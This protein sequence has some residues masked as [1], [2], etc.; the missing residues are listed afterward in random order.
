MTMSR[1]LA[2]RL[3]ALALSMAPATRRSLAQ[4]M[5][6]ELEHLSLIHI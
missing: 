4:G 5:R 2:R 3:C 1:K 6:A